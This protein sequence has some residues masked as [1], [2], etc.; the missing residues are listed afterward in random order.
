V[1][2]R[3]FLTPW[4]GL[5]YPYATTFGAVA[6]AVWVGGWRPA[7]AAAA[8]GFVAC[9]LLFME[10]EGTLRLTRIADLFGT[11]MYV[12]SCAL[13]IGLGHAV[14]VANE[15]LAE[16][17][18][19][20]SEFLAMLSHE[21]RNP[22]APL[23]NGLA[24]MRLDNV[25]E[26]ER[27]QNMMQRQLHHLTRLI[28]DLLDVSRIDRGKLVLRREPVVLQD[29]VEHAVDT[30]R[31]AVA[32]REQRLEVNNTAEPI[33]IEGD[34][35]RVAQVFANLLGNASK[36]SPAGARIEVT[37][38]REAS[39]AIVTVRDEGVGFPPA[40]GARIFDM[41]VQLDAGRARGGGLGLGLALVRSLVMLHGGSVEARSS[42]LGLG[43]E[44]VV[45]LPTL[46]AQ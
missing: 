2:L 16:A 25:P 10:P 30:V 21:L 31:T 18:L 43:A 28:D 38:A 22:L 17:N 20:K 33:A 34:P 44:F 7:A 24:L 23:T 42:G 6:I 15:R 26:R 12:V 4:I 8:L 27:L 29:A 39:E 11:A 36:F 40:D 35:V 46:P 9:N 45:R 1:L 37:V 32:A 13:I 19:R 3:W 14:R 41:F 5:D